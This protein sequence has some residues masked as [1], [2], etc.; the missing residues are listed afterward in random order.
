MWIASA[1]IRYII[2]VVTSLFVLWRQTYEISRSIAHSKRGSYIYICNIAMLA[3]YIDITRAKRLHHA[4][5][6]MYLLCLFIF[7]TH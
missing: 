4:P 5:E 2:H 3:F 7:M 6:R 1:V